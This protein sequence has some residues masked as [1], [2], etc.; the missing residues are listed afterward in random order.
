MDTPDFY[1]LDTRIRPSADAAWRE[2]GSMLMDAGSLTLEDWSRIQQQSALTATPI[3]ILLERAHAATEAELARLL[4][5]ASGVPFVSIKDFDI[6]ESLAGK[7]T[8]KT[9]LRY[10]VLPVKEEGSTVFLAAADLPD[11][12]VEDSLKMLLGG[13]IDWVLA[14]RS[15]LTKSISHFYG[16]GA[17]NIHEMIHT[18]EGDELTFEG[19][20][21]GEGSAEA[22]M[23]EFVHNII[24]EAIKMRATDIHL[25]PFDERVVLRYRID[26]LLQNVPLPEGIAKLKR[27]VASCI[28][29]MANLD[30]ALHLGVE[31]VLLEEAIDR[32]D[33]EIILVLAGFLRLGLDQDLALEAD[34]FGVLDHQVDE[35]GHLVLLVADLGVERR[36]EEV[37]EALS[38][39]WTEVFAIWNDGRG[40]DQV[41]TQ[42]R[43]SAAG[44]GAPVAVTQDGEVLRGIFESIDDVGRLIVRAEDDRRIAISA[45]DVHF[46][47]TASARS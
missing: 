13:Q 33:V 8:A 10:E 35:A 18:T 46:G 15:E 12:I 45:G 24:L 25:E 16:L 41:L 39:A 5:K 47:A 7:L 27:S 28:K 6:R 19:A 38:D 17:K 42:W 1:Q 29:S 4:S 31:I 3:G 36:A 14:L 22:G 37:F 43:A 44:F 32:G 34:L 21:I 40:I 2:V 23:I 26:G 30:I 11:P 20:D 9:A